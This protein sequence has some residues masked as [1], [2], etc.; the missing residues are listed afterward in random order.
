M[1]AAFDATE[2]GALLPAS[3]ACAAASSA[4]SAL[5]LAIS[6]AGALAD[7]IGQALLLAL[8]IPE[9]ILQRRLVL[10]REDDQL[11]L[12]AALEDRVGLE[13]GRLGQLVLA[14]GDRRLHLVERGR[15]YIEVGGAVVLL[16]LGRHAWASQR[17]ICWLLASIAR[18]SA[19]SVC[20]LVAA[21]LV[22]QCG[23]QRGDLLGPGGIAL[24]QQRAQIGEC[25]RRASRKVVASR[26]SRSLITVTAADTA[27][28]LYWH[29]AEEAQQLAGAARSARLERAARR[30]SPAAPV[31]LAER[32]LDRLARQC[33]GAQI[34]GALGR[35]ECLGAALLGVGGCE[36]RKVALRQRAEFA[37]PRGVALLVGLGFDRAA[38]RSGGLD[39]SSA[40][41]RAE[42]AAHLPRKSPL[43][44]AGDRQGCVGVGPREA[45]GGAK[46]AQRQPQLAIAMASPAW[47]ARAVAVCR[48]PAGWS[49]YRRGRRQIRA[50][51]RSPARVRRPR[52]R[53]RRARRAI[54]AAASSGAIVPACSCQAA[55]PLA[56]VGRVGQQRELN[57]V[58]S[59][60]ILGRRRDRRLGLSQRAQ[61]RPERQDQNREG[62]VI[63]GLRIAVLRSLYSASPPFARPG[64]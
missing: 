50:C 49:R 3:A 35:A 32:R 44:Q 46:F 9:Q 40:D 8:A 15:D 34:G 14:S 64:R 55:E 13:P 4:S 16:P 57:R 20:W 38:R 7:Q 36:D 61:R 53:R 39:R 24:L 23:E 33:G 60:R 29:Q 12:G 11:G 10:R 45:C 6:L 51:P 18:G 58:S 26:I 21:Q 42:L 41:R 31:R 43:R 56:S 54:G 5:R 37:E 62:V 52:T 2:I 27:L 30:G 63:A 22:V 48:R 19:T 1:I 47:A 28:V 59:A 25:G 17:A